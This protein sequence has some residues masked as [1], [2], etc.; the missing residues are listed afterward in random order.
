MTIFGHVSEGVQDGLAYL[1]IVGFIFLIK[2]AFTVAIDF[3]VGFKTYV[4]PMMNNKTDDFVNM[5]GKWAVVT[6][7]TQGIGKSYVEELA[8]RGM[9]LVLISRNQSKLEYL[10]KQ[11]KSKY[12]GSKIESNI[13]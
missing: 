13:F 10:K 5:Y 4:L 12:K 7:C 6:G 2:I 1:A 11:L 9:N 3:I 8:R